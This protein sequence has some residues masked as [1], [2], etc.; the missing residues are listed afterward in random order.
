MTLV[1]RFPEPVTMRHPR[2]GLCKWCGGA[3]KKPAIYWHRDCANLYLLHTR[4]A[5]QKGHLVRRDGRKCAQCGVEEPKRWLRGQY[6]SQILD[7]SRGEID[8]PWLRELWSVADLPEDSPLEDHRLIGKMR[9]VDLVCALEV[10]HRTPLWSV[11]HLPPDERR[12]FFGPDN[13]WLLCPPCH[14]AKSKR[15]AADRAALK[16][17]A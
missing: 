2:S 15:E 11:A 14:K 17:A 12:P 8:E 4:P 3:V 13:L 16:R 9:S 6:D 1:R 10:D 7:W 5:D